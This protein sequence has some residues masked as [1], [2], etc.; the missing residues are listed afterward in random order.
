[1]S[2]FNEILNT[3]LIGCERKSL[4]LSQP[5]GKLGELLAQLDLNDREGTLLGA[6]ALVS[7]YERAGSL[8]LKDTQQLPEAS[9]PDTAERCSKV[10]I[11]H[12]SMM[13]RGE[14]QGVLPEWL[15]KLAVA[16]KRV[17]EEL[18]PP[19]LELGRV[20]EGLREYILPVL[21][22]RGR[23]LMSQNPN[24]DYSTAR[25]DETIWETG[26]SE[27]RRLFL[28]ELRKR[29]TDRARELIASTWQQESL[30]DRLN[31]LATY[32][33]N[34]SL[35]DE[36]FLEKV[37][38][39]R[40]KEIRRTAAD[41]LARLPESALRKRM[42]D[43]TRTLLRFKLNKLKRKMLEI[44]L[45]EACD[46]AM[47]RD[48]IEPKPH[49][50]GIGEKAWWLQQM[51]GLIPPKIWEQESGWEVSE[52][53]AVAKRNEWKS[54]LLE[55]WSQ[56]A[57]VCR[58]G[59]WAEALL[60]ETFGQEQAVNLFRVL[61]QSRQ[62]SFIIELLRTAPSLQMDKPA[63]H[64]IASYERQWSEKLS[65]AVVDSLL[66]HAAI[67]RFKETWMWSG[68]L[69]STGCRL[70]PQLIPETIARLSKAMKP[71]ADQPVVIEQFLNL[72][73]FRYEILKEVN[74]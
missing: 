62:E 2:L 53:I 65:R 44:A 18:L 11:I 42:L 54:V 13:L 12:L 27:Q 68:F 1:M 46:K 41:L 29:D 56:A 59:E 17:T 43:R 10:A 37:L 14:Y 23:W 32:E 49:H 21:G 15:A 39:D 7:L 30:K 51:L 33:N 9:E 25:F 57:Q 38:D 61:P 28:V 58:D 64:F 60:V 6:A 48:G 34:L 4:S 55:G 26:S 24:W 69:E 66:H 67:D 5:G 47:Q 52:L 3:A 71:P 20:R 73:Q 50:Q 36:V 31:F 74:Q 40:R 63:Y 16:G 70:D 72:I 35:E 22:T 45:P 8:P 19:L